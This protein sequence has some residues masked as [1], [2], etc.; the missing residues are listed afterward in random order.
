MSNNN[1]IRRKKLY[2]NTVSSLVFQM[3]SIV[4][5]FILP[6]FI[7]K[8]YGSEVNGLVNS[9]M[10]FLGIIAFLELGVG[11]VVQSAL[12][13]PLA[14]N[15]L[16]KISEIITSADKFFKRLALILL[17]YIIILCVV[18]PSIADSQF[19]WFYTA[20]LII[21]ISISSFAQYYFGVVDRI[22]LTADQLGYIQYIAQT[23]TLVV[24]TVACVLLITNGASIHA[25]KLTTST[26][27]LV[28]PI[29]LRLY[30]NKRYNINRRAKYDKEPIAQK[31]NGAAQHIAAVILDGTDIIVLTL[32]S[33][34]GNVS[35]YSVY[36]LVETGVKNLFLSMTNGIQSL[37]GELWAKQEVKELQS[38]FGWTEWLIHTGTVIV[39]GC[40]AVLIIPFVSVYTSG[41]TDVNYVQP[42]FALLLSLAQGGHCLRLPYNLMILAGGHYKQTQNNY[43]HV[44]VI[45]ILSSILLV[46]IWGLIGVAIG[47]LIAMLYQTVWMAIYVSKEFIK[48]PFINFIKQLIIDCG[49]FIVAFVLCS[50]INGKCSGY[51]DWIVLAIKNG[52]IWIVISLLFNIVLKKEYCKRFG[53][54]IFNRIHR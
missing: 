4:C 33:S 45:N 46:K 1:Q 39:F 6:R 10:Q 2:Y 15:D 5:G 34:F 21:A 36:N 17:A 14:A 32:F 7:L 26:I 50:F 49:V 23:V 29:I 13:K 27:Y 30:I 20:T 25:V 53:S 18:F 31:W 41:V 37:M 40:T 24:N 54:V 28:R 51:I 19:G 9:I 11:A 16:Q 44:A 42:T 22:L 8:S 48:W 3:T 52:L 43:I 12:Y 38:L 35:I 47:T